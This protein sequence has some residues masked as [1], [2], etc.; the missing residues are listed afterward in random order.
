MERLIRRTW[1]RWCDA[2]VQA[3]P[4]PRCSDTCWATA[5]VAGRATFSITCWWLFLN[6][7][8]IMNKYLIGLS[9]FWCNFGL[10]PHRFI[11][12]AGLFHLP[13]HH[14]S[15]APAGGA[16]AG[17]LAGP[18]DDGQGAERLHTR[19]GVASQADI[20]GREADRPGRWEKSSSFHLLLTS[21][22]LPLS[23]F[24]LFFFCFSKHFRISYLM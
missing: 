23:I 18:Q 19:V 8:K 11:G 21:F 15:T 16:W 2:S 7:K 10:K 12:R 6:I 13:E 1:W 3:P 9:D 22:L 4:P 20:A 24:V 14:A 5:Q 17:D